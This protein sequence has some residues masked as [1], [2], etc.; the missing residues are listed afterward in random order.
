[1]WGSILYEKQDERNFFFL[2]HTVLLGTWLEPGTKKET[3]KAE[4][5][6]IKH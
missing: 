5:A 4:I 2:P 1:M 3:L 6:K